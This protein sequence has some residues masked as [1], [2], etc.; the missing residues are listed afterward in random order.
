MIKAWVCSTQG[1][2]S[3]GKWGVLLN[4]IFIDSSYKNI[5]RMQ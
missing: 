4:H 3:G 2:A 5:Y 1:S